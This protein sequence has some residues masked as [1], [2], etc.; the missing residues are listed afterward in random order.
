MLKIL[1][2]NDGFNDAGGV[3]AY[4]EAVVA[5]LQDRGHQLQLCTHDCPRDTRARN[6]FVAGAISVERD[7]LEPAIGQITS[8]QPDV[9]FSH[10]MAFLEIER[11]LLANWPIVKFMHGYFGTC[12]SGLKMHAFPERVPCSRVF[13]KACLGLYFPRRCGQLNPAKM[14]HGYSWSKQQRELFPQYSAIVVAS[15][16]MRRDYVANGADARKVNAIPLF[17]PHAPPPQRIELQTSAPTVLF[18]GRMTNLKGGDLLIRAVKKASTQLKTSIRLLMIGDGPARKDWE[19][20]SKELSISAT[21][22]GWLDSETRDAKFREA[23]IL[24]MPSVWPEPFGLV[25]LEAARLGVPAIAFDVGGISE[26]LKHGI[27]GILIPGTPPSA[28]ALGTAIAELLSNS[29]QLQRMSEQA[30][31]VASEMSLNQHLQDLEKVLVDVQ[32]GRL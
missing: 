10:N 11:R 21:F 31:R 2:V 22:T 15:E 9:C 23:T 30:C 32:T 28:D 13:G 17:A 6:A 18:I 27:N 14:V 29:Q 12:V 8:W 25:G 19:A 24:C 16:H 20:L 1:I 4:I 26:W 7:G 5:G 3:Q